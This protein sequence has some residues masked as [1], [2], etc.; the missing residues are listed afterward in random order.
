V[1]SAIRLTVEQHPCIVSAM[2]YLPPDGAITL[3]I[4]TT[5]MTSPA[6]DA[7]VKSL[8]RLLTKATPSIVVVVLTPEMENAI[9]RSVPQFFRRKM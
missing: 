9:S 8:E 4:K 7:A 5:E 6:V 2:L 1:V 3:G